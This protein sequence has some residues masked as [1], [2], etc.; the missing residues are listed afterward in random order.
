MSSRKAI[1][2]AAR[3]SARNNA[4]EAIRSAGNSKEKKI[5]RSSVMKPLTSDDV[6]D[7]HN[8]LECMV[9][10]AANQNG[11]V[12][13]ARQ[14]RTITHGVHTANMAILQSIEDAEHRTNMIAR[15][16]V[17]YAKVQKGISPPTGRVT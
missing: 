4:Y 1:Q 16:E 6:R 3:R 2:I 13:M 8:M 10:M 9:Y 14:F 15:Y 11:R 12:S 17:L 5:T 7:Y